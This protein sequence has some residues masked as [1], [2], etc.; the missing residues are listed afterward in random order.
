MSAMN[1]A[2]GIF[3]LSLTF[4]GNLIAQN[5]TVDYELKEA[6]A[7]DS[8]FWQLYNDCNIDAMRDFFTADIEFYHDKGGVLNGLDNFLSTS[9]RNLCSNDNFRLRREVVAGSLKIFPMNDGDK[10]YG[11]ILSGQHVFYVLE[12]GKEPRLDGLARFTHLMLKTESGWKT[13]RVLSY[14]HGPAPYVNRR[15]EVVVGEKILRRYDGKYKAPQSVLCEVKHANGS[16]ILT[17]G[18]QIF[19]LLPESDTLFFSV[20]RDLT[21]EFKE[22]KMIV[23]EQ[24]KVVEEAIRVK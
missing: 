16:I 24:G 19:K 3:L 17:I 5:K 10:L 12:K 11:A 20:D 2:A 13:S 14:D 18:D 1:C 6:L 21:F 4:C 23:R 22:D 7:R 9:K 8:T 15:K